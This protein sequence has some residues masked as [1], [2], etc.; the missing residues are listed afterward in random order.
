MADGILG[1]EG[2]ETDYNGTMW[3]VLADDDIVAGSA[4]SGGYGLL[5]DGFFD[6]AES[7][8]WEPKDHVIVGFAWRPNGGVTSAGANI[9]SLMRADAGGIHGELEFTQQGSLRISV[10][11][12]GVKDIGNR[13]MELDSWAYIEIRYY[14]HPTAGEIEVR[15]NG[16]PT[17]ELYWTGDTTGSGASDTLSRKINQFHFGEEVNR[18]F[19]Y[20]DVYVRDNTTGL[21]F[22]G[23]VEILGYALQSDYSVEWTRSSG[24]ANYEM[25]DETRPDEDTT[26]VMSNQLTGTKRDL[27][28]VADTAYLGDILAVQLVSRGRKTTTHLWRMRN[29]MQLGGVDA[30]GTWRYMGYPLYATN[31]PDVFPLDPNGNPWTAANFN[32]MKVGFISEPMD[33]VP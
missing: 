8:L 33:N 5:L 19:S 7:W 1:I 6:E 10:Y 20:D 15:V 3:E 16:D 23:D 4:R 30:Y 9:I 14:V 31:P 27:Y 25:V 11:G 29:T 18:S 26:Y 2:F 28:E 22:L 12:K 21:G 32:A 17:P 13:I 24:A